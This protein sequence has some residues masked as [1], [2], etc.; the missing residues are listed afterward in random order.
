MTAVAT[1]IAPN[2]FDWRMRGRRILLATGVGFVV[3]VLVCLP[4]FGRGWVIFLDWVPAPRVALLPKSVFG[5]SGGLVASLPLGIVDTGLS[6]LFGSWST[7]IEIIAFFVLASASIGRLA[8]VTPA[9]SWVRITAAQLLFC[10]NPFVF[11]RLY[12]G[13]IGILLGYALLPLGIRALIEART[14]GWRGWLKVGLWWVVLLSCA[15]HFAWIFALPVAVVG[16]MNLG[17]WR[18][19]LGIALSVLVA[20]LATVYVLVA[21]GVGGVGLKVGPR[22]LEAFRTTADPHLGLFVNVIGLYGFWRLGPTLAKQVI[23]GWP[24]LLLVL[25]VVIVYGYI[26]HWRRAKGSWNDQQV[27][28]L[29]V[30]IGMGGAILAMGSQGPFGWLFTWMYVHVPYF[31]I[32]REPEKFSMLLTL[33]YAI[34]FGWGVEALHGSA[35]GKTAKVVTIAIAAIVVLAYEPLLFW[36]IS[37]QVKTSHYPSSWYA[38]N[39][40]MGTGNGRVLAFPWHQY[41]SYPFTQNRG[42]ANLSPGFF[43]RPVI[44]G[45]NV[46]LPNIP[47]SATSRES[48]FIQYAIDHG[49]QTHYFGSLLTPLGVKYVVLEKTV[50][51]RLYSWLHTQR[52]LKEVMDSRSIVVF[53]NSAYQ[54]VAYQSS[55]AV[56]VPSWGSLL[57]LSQRNLLQNV[58]VRVQHA[59][60]GPV[61]VDAKT[62]ASIQSA[63]R[64]SHARLT[65]LSPT[66]YRLSDGAGGWISIENSYEP[67]WHLANSNGVQLAEG[68]IGIRDSNGSGVVAFANA[69]LAEEADVFSLLVVVAVVG[70]L[71]DRHLKE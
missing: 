64:L 43:S 21:G 6:H 55:T 12:A 51:W 2:F 67:G 47:T 19:I 36:G 39:R 8:S 60:G 62:V 59:V 68:T 46:Q 42:V 65:M 33:S 23:S 52:D 34:G 4:W 10:V 66:S 26:V 32:M 11:G 57:A 35:Q 45:D 49:S 38:A 63:P 3:G 44:S 70:V 16:L 53:R 27:L 1:E 30:A 48:R 22:N 14:S 13:Q 61:E 15:P 31:N 17:H 18:V 20:F 28:I 7:V 50:D 56:T 9:A 54:G 40:L 41:L 5:L 24:I 69:P 58:I 25:L 29:L 37:G 71:T